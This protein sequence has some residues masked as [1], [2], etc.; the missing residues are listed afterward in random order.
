MQSYI[1][2]SQ[3]PARSWERPEAGPCREPSEGTQPC[4]QFDLS[5]WP[6]DCEAINFCCLSY[7]S[8]SQ[9]HSHRFLCLF[10]PWCVF[11]KRLQIMPLVLRSSSLTQVFCFPQRNKSISCD[12]GCCIHTNEEL[13]KII[14]SNDP[15]PS[16]ANRIPKSF[17]ILSPKSRRRNH[18]FHF[19]DEANKVPIRQQFVAWCLSVMSNSLRPYGLQHTRLPCPSLSPLSR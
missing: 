1:I 18:G 6:P 11:V 14:M 12:Q 2:T 4:Q 16:F 9:V 3:E 17:L 7:F 15:S 19:A 10:A 8:P 13:K 5:F